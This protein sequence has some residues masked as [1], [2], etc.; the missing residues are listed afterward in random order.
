MPI[1]FRVPFK[2][3]P[4]LKYQLFK[5]KYNTCNYQKCEAIGITRDV[6]VSTVLFFI[7]EPRFCVVHSAVAGAW[8]YRR[9]KLKSYLFVTF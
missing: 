7:S 9:K 4:G 1:C 2:L 5:I 8:L 6:S 3:P